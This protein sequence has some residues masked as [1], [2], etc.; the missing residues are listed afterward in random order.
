MYCTE[1][2]LEAIRVAFGRF[3]SVISAQKAELN[4]VFQGILMKMEAEWDKFDKT[5][6]AL[7]QKRQRLLRVQDA[8]AEILDANELRMPV[9]IRKELQSSEEDNI[10]LQQ[11]R[12][13][14]R[15]PRNKWQRVREASDVHSPRRQKAPPPSNCSAMQS[16]NSE[17][18]AI[19]SSPWA[20]LRD[21]LTQNSCE[22]RESSSSKGTSSAHAESA[23]SPAEIAPHGWSVT[24]RQQCGS[25]R[26]QKTQT[27]PV[28]SKQLLLVQNRHRRCMRMSSNRQIVV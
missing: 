2:P 7:E 25:R 4:A 10:S 5:Q 6:T 14:R 24:A 8:M 15:P 1:E 19:P 16:K 18:T 22:S 20:T 28:I 23:R 9:W 13:N 3:S 12:R 21:S 17:Q 11:P 27:A 26:L